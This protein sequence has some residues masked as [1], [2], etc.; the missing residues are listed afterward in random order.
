MSDKD[1]LCAYCYWLHA[2]AKSKIKDAEMAVAFYNNERAPEANAI[3][4][5]AAGRREDMADAWL[6][7]ERADIKNLPH[8]LMERCHEMRDKERAIPQ[9]TERAVRHDDRE[10]M[11]SQPPSPER[12]PGADKETPGRDTGHVPRVSSASDTR[13]DSV[14]A[15]PSRSSASDQRVQRAQEEI[16]ASTEE[17][18]AGSG[19]TAEQ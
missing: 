15:M 16:E 3:A 4:A 7:L 11:E 18:S 10:R 5:Q 12:M 2:R 19:D 6:L 17:V 13:S 8:S 14:Q 9:P 1:E